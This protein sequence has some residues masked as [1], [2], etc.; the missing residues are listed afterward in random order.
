MKTKIIAAF[1]WS[2]IFTGPIF[3][4]EPG[5]IMSDAAQEQRA[6]GLSLELRCL[7]CQNQSIDDSNADLA[8]DLRVLVR[9][10]IL[11]GDSDEEVKSYLVARYGE[12]VLLKPSFSSH[13]FLLWTLPFFGLLAGMALALRKRKARPENMLSEEEQRQLLALTTTGDKK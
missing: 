3:A 13:T 2:F 9:E 8:K 12:F 11:V 10:R 4:V 1:M 5:E 7:V 6:R